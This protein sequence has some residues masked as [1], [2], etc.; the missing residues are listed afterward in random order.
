MGLSQLWIVDPACD[1]FADEAVWLAHAAGD[2]LRSARI[3]P[4]LREA[5]AETVF[6]IGTSRQVRRQRLPYFTPEQAAAAVLERIPSGPVALVFGRESSGLSNE[7][8]EQCSAQSMI[9]SVGEE[10]SLNLAQAVM[11]YCYVLYQASLQ[12]TE[13]EFAL[14]LATHVEYEALYE[15][16]GEALEALE[17]QPASTLENFLARYRRVFN[18]MPLESRDVRVLLK[19]LGRTVQKVGKPRSTDRP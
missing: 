8:L 15:R 18:R 10:H 7:E 4:T 9:M 17:I 16:I 14:R 5:L 11:V 19:F 3:V 6:S 1:P 2:L 13:R 12:P